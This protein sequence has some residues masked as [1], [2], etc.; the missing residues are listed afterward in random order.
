LLGC[1]ERSL[2]GS[3]EEA[4][5]TVVGFRVESAL[6]PAR[7]ALV[8]R[9]RFS[10]YALTFELDEVGAGR[11]RLRAISAAEFPGAAGGVYRALVV[12]TRGHVVA[13]RRLLAGI[14]ARAE[15]QR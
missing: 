14:R 13:V 1:R 2:N 4:G 10:S 9:H 12:G 6:A 8:G 15:Q 3:I 11:T 7:L 5:S